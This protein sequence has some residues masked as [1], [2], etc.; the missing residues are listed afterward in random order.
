MVAVI[1]LFTMLWCACQSNEIKAPGT[2]VDGRYSHSYVVKPIANHTPFAKSHYQKRIDE[3]EL[4]GISCNAIVMLGDSL[5]E[6]HNWFVNNESVEAENRGISGDTSDGVLQRLE[7]V[8]VS[9]PKILFL[10]IGTNDLWTQ[11][12]VQDITDNIQ[13]AV[14]LFKTRTPNTTIILQTVLPLGKDIRL[15]TKVNAI[16]NFIRNVQ[17]NSKFKVLDTYQ[18]FVDSSGRLA[19]EY[20]YDGVHLNEKAY[21]IWEQNALELIVK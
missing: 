14:S 18:M 10:L 5:T 3:F 15:N 4:R 11:N 21:L 7:E 16:N 6:Q 8:L 17:F 2:C 13:V 1:I 20:T 12:S 9:K 19:E